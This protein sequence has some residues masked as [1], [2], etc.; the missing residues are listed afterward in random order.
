MPRNPLESLGST[1]GRRLNGIF[2]GAGGDSTESDLPEDDEDDEEGE[3]PVEVHLSPFRENA[4][5]SLHLQMKQCPALSWAAYIPSFA[6]TRV[7]IHTNDLA[8]R[9][10]QKDLVSI[11]EYVIE[12]LPKE[13]NNCEVR[14]FSF[15]N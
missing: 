4:R 10:N 3:A 6:P 2:C 5:N 14:V 9:D 1:C 13:D 12:R 7:F 8:G 15:Q 11:G